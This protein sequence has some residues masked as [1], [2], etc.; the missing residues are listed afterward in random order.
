MKHYVPENGSL[1]AFQDK[2]VQA[3]LFG[4]D[5]G[6]SF[7]NQA[8]IYQDPAKSDSEADEESPEGLYC[9]LETLG[10]LLQLAPFLSGPSS[11]WLNQQSD[12][13]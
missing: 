5:L 6:S 10:P 3:V 11:W 4:M 9:S 2:S 8:R 12:S 1:V 13:T 7:Q